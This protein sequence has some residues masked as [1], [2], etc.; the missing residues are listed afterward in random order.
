M[1]SELQQ[2][3]RHAAAQHRSVIRS[4]PFLVHVD[5]DADEPYANYAIPDEG[6]QPTAAEVAALVA[7]FAAHGRRAAFEYLPACAPAVEA[8][9]LAAGL[10]V[11]YRIPVLACPAGELVVVE[12][13]AG[14]EIDVVGA[15]TSDVL[16]RE[17]I[18]MQCAAFGV[19][20]TLVSGE[21]VRRLRER[22]GDGVVAYA[23][24]AGA[25]VAGGSALSIRDGMTELA[26][27]A[28]A[29]PAR[30][31]GIAAALT[32]ALARGAA[33]RGARLP[34]LTP[35]HDEA[36]RAYRRAGFAPIGEMLHLALR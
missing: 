10:E 6:A 21:E 31:R 32:S 34:F 35:G 25:V 1:L 26:G 29:E 15:G 3:L 2:Y 18:A 30:R 5:D 4:G 28:V 9:L 14:V 16:L 19:P 20:E 23:V 7:A 22:A 13:P 24:E 8:P 33:Q 12:P 17:L 11:T 36:G 27:I